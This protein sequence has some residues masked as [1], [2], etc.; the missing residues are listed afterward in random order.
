[1][2]QYKKEDGVEYTFEI[3]LAKNCKIDQIVYNGEVN[4]QRIGDYHI[5]E[6]GKFGADYLIYEDK[7]EVCHSK[8]TLNKHCDNLIGIN[9]LAEKTDKISLI[10]DMKI[11]RKYRRIT[12]KEK[13]KQ[14]SHI[15]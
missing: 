5:R 6:G 10:T 9:R 14:Q 3:P 1:M 4:Q 11:I 2:F 8:Y 12:R 7:P 13:R 15:I